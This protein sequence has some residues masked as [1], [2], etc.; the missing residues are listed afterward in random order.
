MNRLTALG[1]AFL[2]MTLT[3]CATTQGNA[4][5]PFEGF[6]RKVFIFNDK[7]DQVA[8]KPAAKA[9]R[10]VLPSFVQTGVGNFFSNLGDVWTG[11]NNVLQGKV[12]DG[13]TDFLR[14]AL[15]S[16]LG[17]AGLFDISSDAGIPKHK[18]DFGQ[19][20]G[21]WGVVSGPY[22]VLPL[23]G[24]STV[25]DTA[26]L[27]L[28]FK[29]DIWSYQDPVYIRNIGMGV[30]VVDARASV[31]DATDLIESAA[32]DRYV[33]VRDAFLQ[34]RE[35]RVNDGGAGRHRGNVNS[36]KNSGQDGK[37][38]YVPAGPTPEVSTE[39]KPAAKSEL[40]ND[41]KS[42]TTSDA[43]SN[44]H[45]IDLTAPTPLVSPSAPA[46]SSLAPPTSASTSSTSSNTLL[47]NNVRPAN[48][49]VYEG[50]KPASSRHF[51]WEQFVAF[52]APA[53]TLM[54]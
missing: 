38:S 12:G 20:L 40:Q 4:S 28:D 53:E 42:D 18:E 5:D 27:P 47:N 35:S 24:S 9:Y 2:V 19:T 21:K 41:L 37:D 45:S 26:A 14:F 22:L 46:H 16:T 15:N 32:L 8:L 44:A 13:A 23:L 50:M 11:I 34:R 39:E 48:T 25:R 52:R 54:P 51:G 6:N 1:T 7:L 29:G 36:E 10:A 17:L 31:L 43:N 30:R 49:G 33:F 3:G